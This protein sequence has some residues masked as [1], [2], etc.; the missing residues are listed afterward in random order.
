MPFSRHSRQVLS[1]VS[2]GLVLAACGEGEAAPLAESAPEIGSARFDDRFKLVRSVTLEQPDSALIVRVSGIDL[3]SRGRILIGDVS[4]GNVKLFARDGRLLRVI[5]RKG[6]GP[7]EF[8]QP[9][10]PRF[11][12]DGL[13]YVADAQN[14]R[15]QVFDTTGAL[16]AATPVLTLGLIQ[17]FRP[18]QGRR[19]LLAVESTEAREVLAELDMDGHVRRRMLAVGEIRPTGQPEDPAWGNL[20]AFSLSVKDDTAF[21]SNTVSDS[22]WMVSLSS[23]DVRR[24][25]LP[26]PGYVHP[27]AP[28]A[29]H[30]TIQELIRWSHGFHLSSTLSVSEGGLYLPYVRGVLNKGDPILLVT[31][32]P[33]GEWQA[34]AESPPVIGTYDGGP[35]VLLS[36]GQEEIRIGLFRP[37][38]NP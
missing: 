5:G 19:L 1:A 21:V 8:E 28:T 27:A 15:V 14:P 36:P 4:E 33:S 3:D 34:L 2:L 30:A 11:G 24:L 10:Y 17:G 12:P 38:A 6:M 29:R 22:L 7:G 9:R 18:L 23:G 26:F 13:I 31:R 37:R 32:S 16:V 35:V 20:R 25:H